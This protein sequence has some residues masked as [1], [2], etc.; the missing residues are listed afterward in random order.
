[1]GVLSWHFPNVGNLFLGFNL[2]Y[3]TIL[4]GKDRF[5]FF[6]GPPDSIVASKSWD[7]LPI[8]VVSQDG[9]VGRSKSKEV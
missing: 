2:G 7:P 4:K 5:P 6:R 3:F 1:M 8:L 9:V